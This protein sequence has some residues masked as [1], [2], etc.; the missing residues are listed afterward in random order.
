MRHTSKQAREG[1][2][3]SGRE[4]EEY[5]GEEVALSSFLLAL[6][7]T[8]AGAADRVGTGRTRIHERRA[9][10]GDPRVIH[11]N[12]KNNK[13]NN[14]NDDDNDDAGAGMIGYLQQG[15]VHREQQPAPRGRGRSP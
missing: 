13:N 5:C 1:K 15:T 10:D 11:N 9:W 7:P 4:R 8:P 14:N 12:N 6:G 3:S 2:K